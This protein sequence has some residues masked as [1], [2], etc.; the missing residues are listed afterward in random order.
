VAIDVI[1]QAQGLTPFGQ[2]LATSLRA[3]IDRLPTGASAPDVRRMTDDLVAEHRANWR[4]RNVVPAEYDLDAWRWDDPPTGLDRTDQVVSSEP[5]G[6]NPMTRLAMAWLEHPEQVR[7]SATDPAAFATRFPGAN[8]TDLHLLDGDYT[9]AKRVALARIEDGTASHRDW[10][11][12]AV[13]HGRQCTDP[14]LSPLVRRPELVMAA[15]RRLAPPSLAAVLS[16]YE[17][18]GSTSDSIRR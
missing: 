17:A 12:L 11:T 4:L 3:A 1:T 15:W 5:S 8:P 9:A 18:G 16:R 10:A 7:A 6:D 2:S 13:A 14:S